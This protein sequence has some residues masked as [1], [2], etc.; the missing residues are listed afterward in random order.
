M[1]KYYQA[2]LLAIALFSLISLLF[3]RHEYKKLRYVLEVFNY[4]GKPVNCL[5]DPST[6]PYTWDLEEPPSS[7]QRIDDDV[8]LYSAYQLQDRIRSIGIARK[9]GFNYDCEVFRHDL[10]PIPGEF[11]FERIDDSSDDY[12]GAYFHCKFHE[13][14]D[15]VAV[16]FYHKGQTETPL[17]PVKKVG[18]TGGNSSAICISPTKSDYID[19]ATFLSFHESIGFGN[20]VSYDFGASLLLRR[21]LRTVETTF[22]Y[23]S[24]PWNFPRS[25]LRDVSRSVLRADCLHR[26]SEL[27]LVAVLSWN[28]YLVPRYHRTLRDLVDGLEVADRYRIPVRLFCSNGD[29]KPPVVLERRKVIEVEDT[30]A[31]ERPK[32]QQSGVKEVS[33]EAIVV[34][35]YGDCDESQMAKADNYDTTILRFVGQVQRSPVYK[36]LADLPVDL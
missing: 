31:I 15:P 7:W 23:V 8:Y 20:F 3:Y 16:R 22:T 28:E 9:K 24:L 17:L 36:R 12:V 26:T 4:F 25:D 10:R 33:A 6:G 11:T 27:A 18:S 32:A 34:N 5:K 35:R 30:V 13:D 14:V 21:V 19:A 2:A 29:A 1:R